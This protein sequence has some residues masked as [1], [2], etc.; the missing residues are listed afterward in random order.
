M[1]WSMHGRELALDHVLIMGIVNVTPDSFSDSGRYFDPPAA[2]AHAQQLITDGADIIDIGGES[3][4]PGA[5]E[6]STDEEIRRVVPLIEMLAGH[7]VPLSVDTSKPEVMRAALAAGAA[8]INDVRAL[9]QSGAAEVVAEHDCGVVLM[10][11]QG[12]PATM[13]QAPYY[14]NVTKDVVQFL[15][16]RVQYAQARGIEASRIAIDPG[17]GFGKNDAHNFAL[18]SQ[19][20]EFGRMQVPIVVGL[21]RKSM[22]GRV[23]GRAADRTAASVAAALL[24]AERGANIVRVHDVA[25]TRD[26]LAVLQAMRSAER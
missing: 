20:S 10:H 9:Q 3:T 19:L 23:S 25:A 5:A 7:T 14:R 24:A 17:F 13:Q 26:A 22:L 2:L 21:S 15:A 16:Q 1:S 12:T 18:L 8:I 11:M 4:R 6:V